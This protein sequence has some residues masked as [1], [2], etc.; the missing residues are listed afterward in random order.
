MKVY[1][2]MNAEATYQVVSGY[3]KHHSLNGRRS[4]SNKNIIADTIL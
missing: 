1:T 2:T 3:A 4:K